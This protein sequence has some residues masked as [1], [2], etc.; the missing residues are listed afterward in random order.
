MVADWIKRFFGVEEVEMLKE[1]SDVGRPRGGDW[2]DWMHARNKEIADKFAQHRLGDRPGHAVARLSK[3]YGLTT[4]QI[5]NILK[6]MR[7]WDK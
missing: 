1:I 7:A 6:R 2:P 5:R 4:A 3:D